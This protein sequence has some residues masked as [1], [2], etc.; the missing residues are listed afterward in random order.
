MRNFF[1]GDYVHIYLIYFLIFW[2]YAPLYASCVIK[3]T[4]EI[5]DKNILKEKY[6]KLRKYLFKT[7]KFSEIFL[8]KGS[9]P[10]IKVGTL[11]DKRALG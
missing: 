10:P 1:S 5:C 9:L 7:K 2:A 4:Y 8:E 11:F 3:Q 6:E